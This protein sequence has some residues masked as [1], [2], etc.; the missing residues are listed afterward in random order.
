MDIKSAIKY[1]VEN[2]APASAE[3]Y[4][5]A[6]KYLQTLIDY[7]SEPKKKD[8]C[9]SCINYCKGE[10]IKDTC[11]NYLAQ[12]KEAMF[13]GEPTKEVPE[14][15]VEPDIREVLED[16]YNLGW[17]QRQGERLLP[18]EKDAI[19]RAIRQISKLIKPEPKVELEDKIASVLGEF[20]S[21]CPSCMWN[22]ETENNENCKTC[23]RDNTKYILSLYKPSVSKVELEERAVEEVIEEC[24][25]TDD[26]YSWIDTDKLKKLIV[27]HFKLSVPSVEEIDKVITEFMMTERWDSRRLAEN[28][29]NLITK[30]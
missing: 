25:E 8:I 19:N 14:P 2:G 7:C 27:S 15:K 24:R 3:E 28:I 21:K 16:I 9:P 12:E 4:V 26:M 18:E 13:N 17:E 6:S 29:H 30:E 5:L 23:A 10:R 20:R 1:F 11:P 22:K